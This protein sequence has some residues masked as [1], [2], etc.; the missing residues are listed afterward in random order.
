MVR[1]RS[2]IRN[3]CNS[4]IKNSREPFRRA[5]SIISG[6][7]KRDIT[8]IAFAR[9]VS[10]AAFCRWCY[11]RNTV[12]SQTITLMMSSHYPGYLSP[13]PPHSPVSTRLP[14]RTS[15]RGYSRSHLSRA[16]HSLAP[17]SRYQ[18]TLSPSPRES[19]CTYRV[20]LSFRA[21]CLAARSSAYTRAA[22]RTARAAPRRGNAR[23]TT[24][25]GRRG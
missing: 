18:N 8:Q 12:L 15:S 11:L 23:C 10:I 17:F 3:E 25:R 24:G 9:A 1:L 16:M 13:F 7:D 2:R 22:R 5:L 21:E 4:K 14:V 20:L 19:R 6:R